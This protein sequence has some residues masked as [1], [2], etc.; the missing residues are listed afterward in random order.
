MNILSVFSGLSKGSEFGSFRC[1]VAVI[2]LLITQYLPPLS[3]SLHARTINA[4]EL[5]LLGRGWSVNEQYSVPYARIP[6]RLITGDMNEATQGQSRCSTGLMFNFSTNS[7]KIKA[8]YT[9]WMNYSM[10]HQA[11]TGTRGLD[12]YMY[13]TERGRWIYLA[14][15]KP[16]QERVQNVDFVAAFDGTFHDFLVYFPLYDGVMDISLQIDDGAEICP[17]NSEY[18]NPDKKVV[19]YGT[20]VTQGGCASRTGMLGSSILGRRLKCQTYNFGFSNGGNLDLA[21]ARAIKEIKGVSLYVIDAIG[22]STAQVIE[23]RMYDF[24]HI[25]MD[26]NPNASFIFVEGVNPNYVAYAPGYSGYRMGNEKQREIVERLKAENPDKKFEIV[27]ASEFEVAEGEGSVDGVHF[28]DL[29]FITWARTVAPV[30]ERMMAP[31]AAKVDVMDKETMPVGYYDLQG[32][33][34]D[35]PKPGLNIEVLSDGSTRK[36]VRK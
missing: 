16:T 31:V 11:T 1:V 23:E 19:V 18:M 26:A 34:L 30:A 14:T 7:K 10:P 32:I 21:T 9:P 29:G 3:C 35:T 27:P 36:F 6:S 12:L 28:T 33:S 24:V 5:L 25:L 22:N 4:S 2:A 20:S 8:T 13:D 17:A 15:H